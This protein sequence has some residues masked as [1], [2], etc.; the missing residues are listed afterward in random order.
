MSILESAFSP[1]RRGIVGIDERITTP[2]GSQPLVYADW[3][4]SGRLF[5]PI[6][7]QLLERVGPFV[8]NTHSESSAT[9]ML[10]THAY[11]LAHAII[12]AHVNAGP[13]DVIITAGSGMTAVVNKMIR[14]LG[15]RIPEQIQPFCHLAPELRPVVFV[16]HMEHHSNQTSWIETIADVEI[17]PPDEQGLVNPGRLR[18]LLDAYAERPLKIGAFTACSNVTGICTPYHALARVMHEAHGYCF[19]DFAASGPYVGID[20]HPPDPREKLD[21]I[22]FSPHKFLGGPGYAWRPRVRLGAL[23]QPRAR[24]AGRRHR[25]LD[26]SVAPAQLRGQHRGTRGR[27]HARLSPG[28]QGGPRRAAQGGDGSRTHARPRARDRAGTARRAAL[29]PKAAS[30]R[31]PHPGATRHRLL[32]H[33]GSAL[34]PRCEAAE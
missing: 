22:Y 8:G 16:T 26:Q 2:C 27:R 7:R 32:L 12:K 4:A 6:E 21:A 1:F 24:S 23:S 34:Q 33:R 17:V 29:D 30:A 19:V 18:E 14:M 9:G 20:M 25:E 3:T 15:L 13:R 5:E 11:H 31:R 10:M 28:D